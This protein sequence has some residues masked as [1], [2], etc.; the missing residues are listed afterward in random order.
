MKRLGTIHGPGARLYE[1]PQHIRKG[2]RSKG[3]AGF[4]AGQSAADP[5]PALR[6]L[7]TA[8]A[9][10][11]I[12]ILIAILIFS[13][14]LIAVQTV[15]FAA[16]RLQNR[17]T[18]AVQENVPALQVVSMLKK[19]LRGILVTE[20]I[21]AGP[22]TGS[23]FGSGPS[24]S[25]RIE[26]HTTTGILRD[27]VPW[28]DVQR[29]AYYLTESWE[30]P[31]VR[32]YDLVRVTTRNLLSSHRADPEEEWLLGGL[33]SLSFQFFDGAFWNDS[34]ESTGQETRTLQA[35]KVRFDFAPPES[36]KHFREPLEFVAPIMVEPVPATTTNQVARI[37]FPGGAP[38]L[39]LGSG[40]SS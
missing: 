28:G 3:A 32:S 2:G 19:D 39:A 21:L 22:V 6:K 30:N 38:A 23:S 14:V 29:V 26:F 15:F 10:T 20:G 9:F 18:A 37:R 36:G 1:Q 11:L 16:L 8:A 12:E 5:R 33:E 34:W 13:T 4:R 7:R 31:R 25:G 24:G 17:A 40:G 35:I 27:D